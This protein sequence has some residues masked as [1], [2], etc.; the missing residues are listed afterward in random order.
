MQWR[1]KGPC[2]FLTPGLKVSQ[3]LNAAGEYNRVMGT[4]DRG[5]L[6]VFLGAAPGA[7]KTYAMLNE[8]AQL[9]DAGRQVVVATIE[10]HGRPDTDARAEGLERVPLL[11]IRHR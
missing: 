10:S 11:A 7:G 1:W 8:G 9:A 4:I 5:R 3:L 2:N 6:Y